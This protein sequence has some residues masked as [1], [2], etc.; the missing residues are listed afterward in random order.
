MGSRD[1]AFQTASCIA[2]IADLVEE[3]L[4]EVAKTLRE[5]YVDDGNAFG[6][7]VEHCN[8]TLKDTIRV[9]EEYNFRVHKIMSDNQAVLKDIPKEKLS[10]DTQFVKNSKEYAQTTKKENVAI[11]TSKCLGVHFQIEPNEN[12]SYI[13]YNH[14]PK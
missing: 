2:K 3:E 11:Q 4:P 6:D 8:Q 7:S 12:K 14:W 1:A 9:L 10:K 5:I 13:T